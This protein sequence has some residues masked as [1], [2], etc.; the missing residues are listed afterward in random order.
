M[1][2]SS[3]R[4]LSCILALLVGLSP[5]QG[6][7]AN[8]DHSPDGSES[9]HHEMSSLLS[10]DMA[11]AG[12]EMADSA[13]CCAGCECDSHSVCNSAQCAYCMSAILALFD[14]AEITAEP[15]P[16]VKQPELVQRLPTAL[17]R[18]PEV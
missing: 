11:S 14:F 16:A 2:R 18:P 10:I 3:K 12:E 13:D 9:A 15:V 4:L 8:L 6:V 17:F 7:L 5:L 1:A